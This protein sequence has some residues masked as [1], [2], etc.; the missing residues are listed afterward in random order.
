MY[1]NYLFTILYKTI[2][3]YS[4]LIVISVFGSWFEPIRNSKVFYY[5]GR[6]TEPYLRLFKIL[7][8]LGNVNVDISPVIGLF[9]LNLMK[10]AITWLYYM[11]VINM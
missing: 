7:I 8:P 4:F 9:I 2:D 3:F 1:L 5:I 6:V 11:A 10:R